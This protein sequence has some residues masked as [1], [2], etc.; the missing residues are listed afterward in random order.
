[1]PNLAYLSF[2]GPFSALYFDIK[3]TSMCRPHQKLARNLLKE[4]KNTADT[5]AN[6]MFMI[7]CKK[8]ASLQGFNVVKVF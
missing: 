8:P 6:R 1:M 2:L 3:Y 7:L 5:G 4:T